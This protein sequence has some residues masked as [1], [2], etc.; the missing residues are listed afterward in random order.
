MSA[1]SKFKEK[2]CQ[3]LINHMSKGLSLSSFMPSEVVISVKT[4]HE[5]I[6]LHKNFKE[7]Y[8]QG[9][10]AGLKFFEDLECRKAESKDQKAQKIDRGAV[11]FMLSRRFRN[12]YASIV[13]TKEAG[14]SA[15]DEIMDYVEG[16]K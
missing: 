1:K 3:E 6:K 2:F 13:E 8:T 4:K 15:H 11:E 12:E 9:Y 14:R 7:A 5:W 16:N 10:A